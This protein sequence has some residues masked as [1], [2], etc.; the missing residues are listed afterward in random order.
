MRSDL[1]FEECIRAVTEDQ[2]AIGTLDRQTCQHEHRIRK[3]RS[4][5]NLLKLL[6]HLVARNPIIVVTSEPALWNT[7]LVVLEDMVPETA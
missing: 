7:A 2:F 6:D 3:E 4:M 5:A 1:V